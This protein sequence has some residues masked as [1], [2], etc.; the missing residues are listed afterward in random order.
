MARKVWKTVF[1]KDPLN[2]EM[3]ER[4]KRE[5]LSYGGGKDPW[6]MVATLLDVPEV[7]AGD[8]KAMEVV[9][10]WGVEE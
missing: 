6:E 5:M 4:Y 1:E 8:K 7:A 10:K 2:R 3:G 9:G